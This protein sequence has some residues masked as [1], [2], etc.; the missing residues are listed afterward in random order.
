M[1][2]DKLT[3]LLGHEAFKQ[4]FNEMVAAAKKTAEPLTITLIDVDHFLAVNETFGHD[5]GD[6]VLKGIA[7]ILIAQTSDEVRSYRISGDEFEL[8]FPNTRREQAFLT[9]ERIRRTVEETEQYGDTKL[10]VRISGGVASFPID[11]SETGVLHR[12]A[13]QAIYQAKMAGSNQIR[14]AYDER[15]VPK[16]VHFTETQLERLSLLSDTLQASEA[17]LL[18]EALDGL[19]NKYKDRH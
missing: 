16:T 18:R 7:D 17:H 14:L 10:K 4:D 2:T 6:A 3:G 5:V 1:D 12:K 13:D 11:G 9:M 19:L 8:L 15:M